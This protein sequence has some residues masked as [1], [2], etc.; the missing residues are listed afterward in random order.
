MVTV[1][2]DPKTGSIVKS[3]QDQQQYLEDGTP[4]ADVQLTQTDD[5]VKEAV[6]EAKSAGTMLTILLT[7][8]P[9][10][11]IGGGILCLLGGVLLILRERN[12]GG[13]PRRR[14]REGKGRPDQ[15]GQ[16]G[17]QSAPNSAVPGVSR[18]RVSDHPPQIRSWP[19]GHS[20]SIRSVIRKPCPA[21]SATQSPRVRWCST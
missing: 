17:S 20:G 3:G 12:E 16:R 21:S 6:D 8:V 4:A 19:S 9:I 15:V 14:C 7:V 18:P 13:R 10:V 11:G 1:Y 2:V 5:S